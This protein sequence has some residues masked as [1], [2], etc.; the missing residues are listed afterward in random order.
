MRTYLGI[1]KTTGTEKNVENQNNRDLLYA[2][3]PVACHQPIM[4]N[5]AHTMEVQCIDTF[6]EHVKRRQQ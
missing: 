4:L 6:L 1:C 3:F 2:N 5:I